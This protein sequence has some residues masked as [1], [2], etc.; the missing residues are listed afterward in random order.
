MVVEKGA[1]P[2]GST[3]E[4]LALPYNFWTNISNGDKHTSLLQVLGCRGSW[5]EKARAFVS[6]RNSQAFS[7][8]AHFLFQSQGQL[9]IPFKY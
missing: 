3:R 7:S 8:R 6:R 1:L 5:A 9:T 4:L 2:V